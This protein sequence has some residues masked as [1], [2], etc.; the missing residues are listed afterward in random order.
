MSERGQIGTDHDAPCV[1]CGMI[2]DTIDHVI[3]R[4]YRRMVEEHGGW[5]SRFPGVP[6]EVPACGECNTL[7]GDHVFP[8]LAQKREYIHSQ[9]ERRY[10]SALGT[11]HWSKEE[12]AE[13][14]PGLRTAVV[15]SLELAGVIRARL[16]WPR[17]EGV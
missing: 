9:L 1:Y 16:R 17:R 15:G 14:G 5:R 3:P 2:A 13:L 10:K 8:T 12:L 4:A 6:D 11:P 7:A